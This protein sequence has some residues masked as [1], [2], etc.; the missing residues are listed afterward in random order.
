MLSL[1]PYSSWPLH[2]KLFHVDAVREWSN[3]A[4]IVPNARLPT[5]LTVSVELEGVD[6]TSA[7]PSLGGALSVSS[8]S[9]RTTPIDVKDSEY[10]IPEFA[11][12]SK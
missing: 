9:A 4:A 11:F 6:G 5:G 12:S 1:P 8:G 7:R 3:A 10:T 2:V